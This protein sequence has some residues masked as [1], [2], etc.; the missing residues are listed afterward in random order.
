MALA[1]QTTQRSPTLA[2]SGLGVGAW[3]DRYGLILQIA[4]GCLG[5]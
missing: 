1:V 4:Q 5:D 3:G 2:T